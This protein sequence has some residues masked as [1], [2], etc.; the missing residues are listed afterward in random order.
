MLQTISFVDDIGLVVECDEL[1][2]G[3]MQLECIATDA[4]RWGSNN[5]VEFEVSKTEVLVFSRRRKVLQKARNAVVRVGEQTFKINQGATKWLGFWLDPKLSF[6]T[7]FEKRMA[8]ANGALRRV[9]SLSSSNGGLSVSLM[10][11]VVVAAVT[12]VALYGA[13]V[14][15]R[16]QQYRLKK[17]QVLLNR[18]A[19]AITGLLCSTHLAFL[20]QE[21]RLPRAQDL[22][23]YR[24]T[25]YAIRA[26]NADGDHPTHQLLPAN[27][28][29]GEL[30]RHEGATGQPSSTGWTRLEKMHRSFGS[31]LAQQVVRH[32]TY[33]A[34]YGFELPCKTNTPETTPVLRLRDH[35]HMPERM[36][37]DHPQ[38]VTL[39][40]G[41]KKDVSFGVGAAWKESNGWKTK[42]ASLGK[43]V[44]ES[45]T[46]LS[47][48][49][50]VAKVLLPIL[51][52][53]N[54]QRAEIM[55]RSKL[56]LIEVQSTRQWALPITTKIKEQTKRIEEEGGRVI[57][58]WLSDNNT[59]EGYKVADN[60]AERAARQQ[61]RE[62]RS[63]SLSYI[64]Q[65]IK[66]RWTPTIKI[67]KHIRDAKKLVAA[68]YL[69]LKLGY[70][71]IG[72][73]LLR[74]GE[75]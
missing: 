75:A 18:Q 55:T 4:M 11:R 28:R 30:Y 59:R 8:S 72:V 33:D 63:A 38:Q 65:A 13:E 31:R 29:L 66:K 74:I 36:L 7:H 15:W 61:L 51:S 40:V 64:K 39:F 25:R 27:F 67:N 19:K 60:A 21:S 24:Q 43:F 68:R 52:R 47:A 70:A 54:Q 37:P 49:D 10:Q 9:A 23:D 45:E 3:T 73:H 50:M 69:Q 42:A 46:V 26:L 12:S 20:W 17:L 58:T 16:G 57:L 48:I 14:W 62:M 5:K 56:A 1:G 71:V 41:A 2:R 35:S 53:T 22:L 32:V 6:K 44:T 34:E